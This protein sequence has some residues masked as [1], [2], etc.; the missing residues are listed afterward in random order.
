MNAE[1]AKRKMDLL[2]AT[3]K[4]RKQAKLVNNLTAVLILVSVGSAA[5]GIL[6]VLGSNVNSK[7]VPIVLLIVQL[8]VVVTLCI[9]ATVIADHAD[10]RALRT[11]DEINDLLDAAQLQEGDAD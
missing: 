8:L 1:S 7:P 3:D 10:L 11:Q 4:V 6:G 9:T 2:T 5:I